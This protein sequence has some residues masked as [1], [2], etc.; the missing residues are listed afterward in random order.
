[1]RILLSLA[2][3][4]TWTEGES[5]E[6]LARPERVEQIKADYQ[7]R[8]ARAVACKAIN[9]LHEGFEDIDEIYGEDEGGG[10]CLICH[11]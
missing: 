8:K 11:K 4:F 10:A 6:E 2:S 1:M 7:A 5:L 9:P 3:P